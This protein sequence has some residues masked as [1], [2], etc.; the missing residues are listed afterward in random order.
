MNSKI[1]R[2]STLIALNLLL[3]KGNAIQME[4]DLKYTPAS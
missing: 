4:S 3:D 1:M 2:L